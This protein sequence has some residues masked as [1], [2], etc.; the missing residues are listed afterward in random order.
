MKI[1]NTTRIACIKIYHYLVTMAYTIYGTNKS[2]NIFYK[3]FC[4]VDTSITW[5]A[6]THHAI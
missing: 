4:Y 6:P 1:F 2:M 5:N 3:A